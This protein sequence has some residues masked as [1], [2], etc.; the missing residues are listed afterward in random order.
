MRRTGL[1]SKKFRHNPDPEVEKRVRQEIAGWNV[2]TTSPDLYEKHIITGVH[3]ATMFYSYC[4]TDIQVLTAL[5]SFLIAMTD[6]FDVS[7]EAMEEFSSR[8]CTGQEQLHPVLDRM[9]MILGRMPQYYSPYAAQSIVVSTIQFINAT[10]FDKNTETMT[11]CEGAQSFVDYKRLRSGIGE[12]YG[13]F[14]FD[15]FT[16]PDI[17]THVQVIA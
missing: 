17:S 2:G 4:H 13:F 7:T 1:Y 11:P 9:A 14:A 5:Y 16:F 10:A 6:D 15:K 12:A 3:V 8:L